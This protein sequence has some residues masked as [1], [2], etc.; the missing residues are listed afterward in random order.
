MQRADLPGLFARTCMLLG[1]DGIEVLRCEVAGVAADAVAV[2][3]LARLAL[4]GRR[5]G[6]QVWLCG[7]C[8]ELLALVGFM[9]LAEVLLAGD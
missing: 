9:G 6:C 7:A 1:G 2:D 5:A 4:A 8:E 3:A